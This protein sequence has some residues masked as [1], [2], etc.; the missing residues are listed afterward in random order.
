MS[1]TSPCVLTMLDAFDAA[2]IAP[3]AGCCDAM[4]V[5]TTGITGAAT[6]FGTTV[7]G[8]AGSATEIV[9]AASSELLRRAV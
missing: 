8:D 4:A 2:A 5:G 3:A 9:A 1:A 6:A 7:P